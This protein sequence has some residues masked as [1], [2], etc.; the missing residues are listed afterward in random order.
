[1]HELITHPNVAVSNISTNTKAVMSSSSN[2][3]HSVCLI[4]KKNIKDKKEGGLLIHSVC[5]IKTHIKDKKERGLLIQW[6]WIL[7]DKKHTH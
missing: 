1:M 5:L 7:F 3:G 4:K 2:L 6:S